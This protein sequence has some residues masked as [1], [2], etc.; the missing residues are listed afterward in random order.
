MTSAK[1]ASAGVEDLVKQLYGLGM[2][3]REIARHALA[4]LGSEGFNALAAIDRAGSLRVSEVATELQVDLSVA[5]RQVAALA[6]SGYVE[7]QAEA[8]DRRAQRLVLTEAGT[9]ALQEAHRRMVAAFA[10]VL[11]DWAPADFARL[12]GDIGRLRT[13]FIRAADRARTDSEEHPS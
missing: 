13:D 2:V 1:P 5:S 8:T 4:E 11:R 7:R 6:A 9:R 12:A 10:D 3:R